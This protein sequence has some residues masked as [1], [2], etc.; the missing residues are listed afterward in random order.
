MCS[1]GPYL[2]FFCCSYIKSYNDTRKEIVN[3]LVS[4]I[5][6]AVIEQATKESEDGAVIV[7][8]LRDKLIPISKRRELEWAWQEAIRFIDENESRIQFE[9]GNRNGEDC[10]MMRW[11]DAAPRTSMAGVSLL[12]ASTNENRSVKTWQSP[13]FDKSNKIK[14]PPTPCLKIRQ[15]FDKYDAN[16]PSLKQVIT[17]AI[18]AKVGTSCNIYDVQLDKSSCCVYVLCATNGDAGIVHDQINGW[19]FDTR[20]VSIKFLRLERY[21]ERFPQT[22]SGQTCLKPTSYASMTSTSSVALQNGGDDDDDL[23]D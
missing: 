2:I 3:G 10:R 5:T 4:D 8:H 7:N 16:D 9:V 18:L 23:N 17:D 6:N 21:L 14:D 22:E 15:M 20:L 11:M 1:Y 19:W 13:A 12:S